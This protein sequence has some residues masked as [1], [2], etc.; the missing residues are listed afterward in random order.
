MAHT[1][2]Q[3]DVNLE[4]YPPPPMTHN[5]VVSASYLLALPCRLSTPTFKFFIVY[6]LSP[7]FT[8]LQ[9]CYNYFGRAVPH[10]LFPTDIILARS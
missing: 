2:V 4:C 7:L 1:S 6:C 5:I 8:P 10:R 3:C 9:H